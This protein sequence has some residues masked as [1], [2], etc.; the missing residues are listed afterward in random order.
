MRQ[1]ELR[2]ILAGR[3]RFLAEKVGSA[4]HLADIAGV[5]RTQM[6]RYL[7][8]TSVPRAELLAL[9]GKQLGIPLDWFFAEGDA[10]KELAEL[11]FGTSMRN[12]VQ[13]RKFELPED[14][15]PEGF[16]LFWKQMFS[17]CKKV[18]VLLGKV[19]KDAGVHKMRISMIRIA[20]QFGELGTLW[21][22]DSECNSTLFLSAGNLCMLSFDGFDNILVLG[23]LQKR[24]FSNYRALPTHIFSGTFYCP[25]TESPDRSTIV[26]GALEKIPD[27]TSHVLR[28]A[29]RCG[30]VNLDEVPSYIQSLFHESD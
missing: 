29:R 21:E 15:L 23:H 28:A 4:K 11:A 9:V 30:R 18:E 1:S 12:A 19:T 8:G 5:N 3:L 20:S 2:E 24:T 14:F 7:A 22:Y 26:K 13:H 16:Y 25:Q 6:S 27:S 10:E 17:D